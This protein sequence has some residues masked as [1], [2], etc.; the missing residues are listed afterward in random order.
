[1]SDGIFLE[2]L[3]IFC[4][5]SSPCDA[6]SLQTCPRYSSLA[7]EEQQNERDRYRKDKSK[8]FQRREEEDVSQYTYGQPEEKSEDPPETKVK[9]EKPNFKLSGKLSEE[10][11]TTT[12]GVILKFSE[13]AEARKPTKNWMLYPFKGEEALDPIH[14]KQKSA[15]LVGRD[16]LVVDIPLNH[17][18]CSKQHA[19]IQFR[20]VEVSETRK[21]VKP[22]VLDLESTNGTFLNKEKV[23]A[24]RFYELKE[25]DVLKFGFSTREYVVLN[26]SSI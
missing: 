3:E 4:V 11:R 20:L 8:K 14:L 10:S 26:E 17:P 25:R 6:H 12:S 13:P 9:K 19:V 15:Y 2:M 7:F 24:S 5:L 22:Y 18:S 21:E 16:S 1:M 23:E